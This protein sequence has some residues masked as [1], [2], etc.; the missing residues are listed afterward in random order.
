MHGVNVLHSFGGPARVAAVACMGVV[1][2]ADVGILLV[3]F[4]ARLVGWLAFE[5]AVPKM[6]IA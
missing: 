5:A 3:P 6:T 2:A 1:A 4:A